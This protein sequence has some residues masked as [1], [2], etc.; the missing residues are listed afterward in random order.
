MTE[1]LK[2]LIVD[3]EQPARN[4]LRELLGDCRASIPNLIVGEAADGMQAL[5]CAA[6][7]AADVALVDIHMPGM[8]GIELASHLQAIERPP[9][10]I[11]VTAH[12]QYAV[13]AFEVNAVDYLLKPVRAARLVAA[14]AKAQKGARVSREVLRKLDREPR[15][16]FSVPERGRVRLVP[17]AD[18]VF[19]KAELKYVTVSTREREYLIEDSLTHLEQEFADIFVR[20]HRNCLVARR[21]I[22]GFERLGE[23]QGE[24]SWGVILEG[25]SEPLPVSRRQ[26]SQVKALAKA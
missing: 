26:W 23:E 21:L 2:V 14:L 11:F 12:D 7:S 19:L 3:D 17:V 20:V 10:V 18:A 25:V 15:R 5:D 22:C 16:F 9:A 6:A 8:S 24:T 4:R 1:P 13:Q